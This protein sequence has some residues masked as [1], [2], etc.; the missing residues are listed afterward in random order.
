M[1]AGP[2]PLLRPLSSPT[3]PAVT[4]WPLAKMPDTIGDIA[5]IL[6]R[7]THPAGYAP[8]SYNR[9]SRSTMISKKLSSSSL[10]GT[11]PASAPNAS[12]AFHGLKP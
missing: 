7:S 3:S 8:T 11:G 2:G 4:G 12:I 1:P 10:F 6:L 9:F 5:C